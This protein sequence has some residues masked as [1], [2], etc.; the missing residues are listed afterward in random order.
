MREYVWAVEV[1]A[2]PEGAFTDDGRPTPGWE[3]PN[4]AEERASL[5]RANLM[6]PEETEF[7]WPSMDKIYMSRSTAKKRADLLERYGATAHVVRSK[8]NWEDPRKPA[9]QLPTFAEALREWKVRF[10]ASMAEV[11]RNEMKAGG[12]RP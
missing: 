11:I 4:W 10:D 6:R 1:T 9:P 2:M 12:D 7:F 8:L 5:K 3:P